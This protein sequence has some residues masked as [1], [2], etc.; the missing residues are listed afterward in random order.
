MTK[1]LLPLLLLLSGC[2]RI[3][4]SELAQL[5]ADHARLQVLE[6]RVDLLQN[7]TLEISN[8]LGQAIKNNSK[9]ISLLGQSVGNLADAQRS[10]TESIRILDKRTK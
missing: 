9:S 4:E 7:G 3:S 6:V 10:T 2:G 8:N 1:L 5:R